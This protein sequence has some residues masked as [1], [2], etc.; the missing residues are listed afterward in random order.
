MLEFSA[1][2]SRLTPLPVRLLAAREEVPLSPQAEKGS[3]GRTALSHSLATKP[4]GLSAKGPAVDA[5][6]ARGC[7]RSVHGEWAL[8][9][10]RCLLH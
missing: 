5:G 1:A 7:G 9:S 10:L 4:A 8:M 2:R 3:E 6:I